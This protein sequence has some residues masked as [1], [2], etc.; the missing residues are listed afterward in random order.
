MKLEFSSIDIRKKVQT[1]NFIK[2]RPVGAEFRADRRT[3]I[4]SSQYIFAILRTRLKIVKNERKI[5]VCTVIWK[6]L[7]STKVY[8]P[9]RRLFPVP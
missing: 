4:R 9:N 1:S 6:Y 2:I 8:L 5:R 7:C 3:D